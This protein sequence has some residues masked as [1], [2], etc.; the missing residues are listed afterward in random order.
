MNKYIL[1][2]KQKMVQ[3]FDENGACVP[4]TF[5]QVGPVVV[6]QVKTKETD[7]YDAV[8]VGFGTRKEK[9]IAKAQKGHFKD[10]GNFAHVREFRSQNG[11]LEVKVGDTLDAS[12]FAVGDAIEVSGTSKAKGFQGVVKRHNFAGGSRSHGQKHSEREPGSIGATGPQRVF[13]GTR[14]GGRMGGDRVTVKNL[15]VLGVDTENNLLLI[16]GAVP[17]IKGGLIEVR[18]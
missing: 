7:G 11:A 8:Q 12:S 3:F 9:N 5:V 1:G 13:K 6:T 15:K 14:M 2:T 4:A 18:G 10:L 17:G 16:S